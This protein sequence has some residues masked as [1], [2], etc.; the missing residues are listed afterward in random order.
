MSSLP[1]SSR[2]VVALSGGLDSV[3]LLNAAAS[4]FADR[5]DCT[6][7]ALHVNHQLQPAARDMAEYSRLACD[8]LGVQLVQVRV[9]V[10]DGDS[11]ENE[12]RKARYRA[13]EQH[14]QPDDCLL[15]AHHADDQAETVLF[16]LVRGS[17]VRGLAG[18]PQSRELG[19]GHLCR[20]LLGLERRDIEALAGS[21]GLQWF[22]DPTN[23][24][25]GFDR[26]YLR[27]QV[28][29]PLVHRW[30]GVLGSIGRAARQCDEASQLTARL[31]ALQRR[32][33][34]D[35]QGRLSVSGL[36]ALDDLPAQKNL[37]RW[38]LIDCGYEPPPAARLE[39]ALTD[40][41]YAGQDR[42]PELR[43]EG[44]HL[45]RYRERLYCL[46]DKFDEPVSP[47]TWVT[48]ERLSWAGG[49][50]R[51]IGG[52]RCLTLT[53]TARAGGERLRP[54]PG[55]P[56]RPLK[57][58]L[59]EQGVPPWER[60]RIPLIWQDGELMAVGDLWVSPTL[61]EATGVASWRIV[62][63]RDCR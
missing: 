2:M 24:E 10:S 30:P 38:W 61:V 31:A 44:Y 45:R 25:T 46:R 57:K 12:A 49:E 37:L 54:V 29:A 28:L 34:E 11:I 17:G 26:N 19:A 47:A 42:E 58:W 7:S 35:G 9:D 62:W 1:D 40:L 43:G 48:S 56:S 41:L 23:A 5:D 21:W 33:I 27:H 51:A 39:Q 32:E 16:R 52:G 50:V 4:W 60:D 22:D 8:A 63:E 55:G 18:M 36:V 6:V 20:P 53:V 59:Q 3:F 14:L 15:M 13:F